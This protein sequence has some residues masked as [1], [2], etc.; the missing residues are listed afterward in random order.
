MDM[1]YDSIAN[2]TSDPNFF[3]FRRFPRWLKNRK[4][5]FSKR[6]TGWEE[7][8][9]PTNGSRESGR[10][11]GWDT[12]ANNPPPPHVVNV[13]SIILLSLI[14]WQWLNS[15]TS[16]NNRRW[17]QVQRS[18][19]E[20]SLDNNRQRDYHFCNLRQRSSSRI[21]YLQ[22][23]VKTSSDR[24]IITTYN[25]PFAGHLSWG[26]LSWMKLLH[27]DRGNRLIIVI[28]WSRAPSSV[29]SLRSATDRQNVIKPC[30]RSWLLLT[31][32]SYLYAGW[33]GLAVS[34]LSWCLT[35]LREEEN[36]E[37]LNCR[38]MLFHSYRLTQLIFW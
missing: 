38:C 26:R 24:F 17:E 19:N 34:S 10:G 37:T 7:D 3:Q 21:L 4:V 29:S 25:Y 20:I 35:C 6:N 18:T 15:V 1:G 11:S 23:L 33:E 36:Q 30:P 12:F 32:E 13:G 16:K 9:S 8:Q 27:G 2:D 5:L 28:A 22:G 14:G 31:P